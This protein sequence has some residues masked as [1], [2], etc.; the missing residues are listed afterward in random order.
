[1]KTRTLLRNALPL[2][3]VAQGFRGKRPRTRAPAWAALVLL[4]AAV[5]ARYRREG[6]TVTAREFDALR[7]TD[8]VTFARHYNE[9]VV[10]VEEE[11]EIWGP[12]HRHRH[13]MRYDLVADATRRHLRE[14]GTVLDIGC[15]A[16]IVAERIQDMK[17]RYV[18]LEFTERNLGYAVKKLA[19]A[20]GPLSAAFIRGDAEALPFADDSF[21]VVVLSEVIEHLLRPE[22]AVW[23]VGRVLRPDGVLIMPTNNASEAPCRSPLSHLLAWVEKAAGATHPEL[24]SR[25][26]WIWPD[27]VDPDILPA[28][29]PHV[30]VPHTHHI[31]A[32]VRDLFGAAGLDTLRWWTF[33]FPPPQSAT[34]AWLERRG[35]AGR[36]AVDMVENVARRTPG[37]RRMGCHLAVEARLARPPVAP[38][39]PPGVWPGPFSEAGG[40]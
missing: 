15:G 31:Y 7:R 39:P 12:F 17:A 32:E 35:A 9:H 3:L 2:A 23:E 26:P 34:A 28:G 6:R 40:A 10:T 38:T 24:I 4:W 8:P 33:E 14:G 1:V 5:Y 19:E 20:D 29:S 21:D 27:P 18:G 37:L 22:R 11:F 13:E 25:R 36:R 16:A 30:F